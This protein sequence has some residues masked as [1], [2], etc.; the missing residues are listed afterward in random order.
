[1]SRSLLDDGTEAPTGGAE[2]VKCGAAGMSDDGPSDGGYGGETYTSY[3]YGDG[4]KVSS[5]GGGGKV[6]VKVTY[7]NGTSVA[8]AYDGSE[9]APYS[10]VFLSKT[11]TRFYPNISRC[12]A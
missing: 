3:L 2:A 1:M 11:P 8:V 6:G 7:R 9:T 4:T 5:G 10:G 12:W